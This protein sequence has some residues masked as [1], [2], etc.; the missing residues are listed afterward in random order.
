MSRKFRQLDDTRLVHYEGV[1]HDRRRN[2]TTDMES[3]MY[4]PVATDQDISRRAP[5]QRPFILCEYTHAMGNSNGAMH[6]VYRIC[7]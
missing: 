7:L 5:A 4:T 6:W 2:D 3:Q 1:A